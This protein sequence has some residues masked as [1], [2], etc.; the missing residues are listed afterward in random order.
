MGGFKGLGVGWLQASLAGLRRSWVVDVLGY[1]WGGGRVGGFE[2]GGLPRPRWRQGIARGLQLR[3][4]PSIRPTHL[5]CA[6]PT[7]LWPPCHAAMQALIQC[8]EELFP[9]HDKAQHVLI[10]YTMLRGVS[11]GA[12]GG[13]ARVPGGYLGG[14]PMRMGG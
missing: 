5:P 1:G 10:E 3:G 9:R 7:P 14:E 8:M 2:G 11:R 13:V 12:R 6:L 4:L